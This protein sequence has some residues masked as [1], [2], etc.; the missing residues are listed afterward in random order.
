MKYVK[1]LLIIIFVIYG[2]S[3]VAPIILADE[4]APVI[5]AESIDD[6]SQTLSDSGIE[7]EKIQAFT[8][9]MLENRFSQRQVLEAH[10]IILKAR[11]LNLPIDPLINKA[12]E[13]MAKRVSP[14]MIIQAMN[15]IQSRYTFAE[16]Q[17]KNLSTN[18]SSINSL[19]RDIVAGLTAGIVEKEMEKISTALQQRKQNGEEIE[20]LSVNTYSLAKDMARLGVSSSRVAELVVQVLNR[21]YSAVH[22]N[23]LKTSFISLSNEKEV[24]ELA[25]LFSKAIESGKGFEDL[26][27]QGLLGD[28]SMDSRG[29][30]GDGSVGAGDAGGGS[31]AGGGGG[32]G[33]SGSGG[34]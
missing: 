32:A 31:G 34:R 24:N 11:Q 16:R 30:F 5:K 13:G 26:R 25:G 33:G 3:S 23:E 28:Q 14:D 1:K 19:S 17:L 7:P 29:G 6:S 2:F 4:Q 18:R 22:I 12:N 21:N 15:R 9:S 10:R 8:R 27:N 20:Q